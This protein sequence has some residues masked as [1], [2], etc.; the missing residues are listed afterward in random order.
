LREVFKELRWPAD[1]VSVERLGIRHRVG[2]AK[3]PRTQWERGEDFGAD[4]ARNS[5]SRTPLPRK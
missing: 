3:T 5:A 2:T 1:D 4:V